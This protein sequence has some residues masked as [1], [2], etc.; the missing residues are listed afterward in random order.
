MSRDQGDSPPSVG[1]WRKDY[2][3]ERV[4]QKPP[5]RYPFNQDGLLGGSPRHCDVR[6]LKKRD[7]FIRD[8]IADDGSMKITDLKVTFRQ[9]S[10]SRR[11]I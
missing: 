10:G 6:A 8:S 5:I 11:S 2:W 7:L 1:M 3:N 9:A 4:D